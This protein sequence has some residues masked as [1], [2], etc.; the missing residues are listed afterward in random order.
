MRKAKSKDNRWYKEGLR[1]TS[2]T[3]DV[4]R[5][6]YGHNPRKYLHKDRMCEK[7]DYMLD[8]SEFFRSL[9]LLL[10]LLSVY[11]SISV[12][13]TPPS[14]SSLTLSIALS[15]LS[16]RF[17]SL[18]LRTRR[19][20]NSTRV[21]MI[22]VLLDRTGTPQYRAYAGTVVQALKNSGNALAKVLACDTG[23]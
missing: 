17:S 9:S 21:A 11:L 12:S 18:S 10:S 7:Q 23:V 6:R 15:H 3:S 5:G 2:P 13:L 8:F 1:L 20:R 4:P 16:S 14:L 22:K 19:L